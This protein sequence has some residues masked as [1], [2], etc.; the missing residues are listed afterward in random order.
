[1]TS[2]VEERTSLLPGSWRVLSSVWVCVHVF[3]RHLCLLG[4]LCVES[5]GVR[6]CVRAC[7]CVSVPACACLRLCGMP[8]CLP[9]SARRACLSVCAAC[10][11]VCLCVPACVCLCVLAWVCAC[12]CAC[13]LY[14]HL[15]LVGLLCLESEALPRPDSGSPFCW[16]GAF[17]MTVTSN[18]STPIRGFD[19]CT[20]RHA[21]TDTHAQTHARTHS[22]SSLDMN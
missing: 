14:L 9:V 15:C 22:I 18:D 21:R 3:Y 12:V 4:L 5:W 1:M 6:A 11:P 8:A 2:V 13:V 19:T 16:A 10:L 7:V 20:H 17:L